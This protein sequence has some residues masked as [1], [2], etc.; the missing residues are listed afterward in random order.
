MITLKRSPFQQAGLYWYLAVGMA[1]Q[2]GAEIGVWKG[3]NAV[4]MLGM[5][6]HLK[7]YLIDP[8]RHLPDYGGKD[9]PDACNDSDN[10]LEFMYQMVK[11]QVAKY[12]NAQILRMLSQEALGYVP[13]GSLDFVYI[14]ANH[15]KEHV[16]TDIEG[17]H[18]KVK[19]HGIIAGHD[20]D[21]YHPG[22]VH[23]VQEITQAAGNIVF[24]SSD[25]VWW[26]VKK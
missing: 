7:L 12:P 22:V 8:W 4:T 6:P 14:D 11:T 26:Y 21:M 15:Q 19:S 17:W 24:H 10:M 5:I 13:D 16:K 3:D 1:A 23:A 2:V 25:G 18:K 20:L 9:C